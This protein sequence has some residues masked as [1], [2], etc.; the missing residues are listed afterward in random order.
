MWDP[1]TVSELFILCQFL[2]VLSQTEIDVYHRHTV[3]P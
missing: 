2:L 3:G 1:V